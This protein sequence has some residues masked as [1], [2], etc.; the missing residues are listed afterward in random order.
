MNNPFSNNNSTGVYYSGK[1]SET[2]VYYNI[3]SSK[4]P[5]DKMPTLMLSEQKL[6]TFK[7][8]LR[9]RI[10][11]KITYTEDSTKILK[12]HKELFEDNLEKDNIGSSQ[13]IELTEDLITDIQENM[14]MRV[15]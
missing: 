10:L 14:M 4:L 15:I 1:D 3:M 7:D 2:Y 11:L 12:L 8:F 9:Q 13:E 5:I 6:D